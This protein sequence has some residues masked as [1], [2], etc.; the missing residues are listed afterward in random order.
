MKRLTVCILV[1]LMAVSLAACGQEQQGSGES[2]PADNQ[3]E[4]EAQPADG[5]GSVLIAYFSWAQ[6]AETDEDVDAVTSPS[7]VAPG[8]VQRLAG[9]VQEG[10]GGDVFTIQV[11]EPYPSDL[12]ECLDRA[13]EE[14][15]EN[16]RPELTAQVENMDDYDT[17]FIGYP[18][19]WYGTPMAV[20]SFLEDY[21]FSGKQVYLF[22]SHG[23]GGLANSVEDISD[24]VS[25]GE[26]SENV[27]DVYEED[28]ASSRDDIMDWL[29]Q[30][31]Y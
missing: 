16:A 24:S 15:A 14:R 22:C 26:I 6:N 4:A 20:L 28:A 2:E 31:G 3:S 25:G 21:D 19:W 9:W 11:T 30:L 1:F 7:V 27:F 10:T 8:D 13:N 17:V 12:D 5:D 29:G 23:T 18:N